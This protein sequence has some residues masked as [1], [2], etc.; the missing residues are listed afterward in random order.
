[1]IVLPFCPIQELPVT[2]ST[3]AVPAAS[4]RIFTPRNLFL[5]LLAFGFV[6]L[7]AASTGGGFPLDDSWIHQVYGRNLARLGQWA[8]I[9]DVPSAAS[10]SPLY[11]VVLALGYSLNLPY[12]LWTHAIGALSLGLAGI[13]AAQL[14]EILWTAH[15]TSEQSLR[16]SQRVGWAAGIGVILTWQMIWAGA[17]GMETPLFAML[18]LAVMRRVLSTAKVNV[19]SGV[20]FGITG[21]FCILARPE[22][23]LLVGLAGVAMIVAHSQRPNELIRWIIGAA[24]GGLLTLTPYFL[25]NYALTGGLLPNTAAA[26]FA[27]HEPLL[28]LPYPTRLMEMTLPLLIGGQVML[29]PSAVLYLVSTLQRRNWT[30]RT[31]LYLLHVLWFIGLVALYAARLPASYQHGRY[32]L[33]ALPS[34]ILIGILG[35]SMLLYHLRTN[36][37]GR[38]F[39]RGLAI[40]AALLTVVFAFTLGL[41]AYRRDVTIVNQEMVAAAQWIDANIPPDQL[42]AIHDI[43]AVGYFT[44][45][46]MLD[47]AGLLSPEVV[48]LINH[49][50]ELWALMQREDARYL[51]A[52]PDQI[53]G[54]N[55]DD[56][57]LCLVFTSDGNEAIEAGGGNMAVYRLN[58]DEADGC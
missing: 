19:V 53:P 49:P 15:S 7:Y 58:W 50:D 9:P 27:Q 5:L 33:P 22:G 13:L 35:T 43:G 12:T 46:P 28:A 36:T 57:R 34:L 32:V 31:L 48:P 55:V 38:V 18:T 11:T 24:V 8:F 40:A 3:A 39:S 30:R 25:L 47:I 51:M 42:L 10:T 21:G 20:V 17:A 26:K 1:V 56:P 54:D 37:A 45:R 6:A 29:I 41:D 23:S 4:Q 2:D 16:W 52:F 14:A 44:P